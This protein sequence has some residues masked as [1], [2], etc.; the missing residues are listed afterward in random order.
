NC[1]R[2][3]NCANH[4]EKLQF[5]TRKT[6]DPFLHLHITFMTSTN[7]NSLVHSS[8][9]HDKWRCGLHEFVLDT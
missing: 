8:K 1:Y 5:A 2:G 9:K 3:N 7:L 4:T 6:R